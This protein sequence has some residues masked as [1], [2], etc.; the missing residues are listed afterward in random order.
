[1]KLIGYPSSKADL[2]ALFKTPKEAIDL[3]PAIL[4]KGLI[5]TSIEFMDQLSIITSCRYLNENLPYE[6]AGAML[7]I[8]LDGGN[9]AQIEADLIETGKLCEANGTLEVYVAEDRNSIERMERAP[10]Y[11][12]SL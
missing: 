9:A 8:E 4:S 12:R 1:V 3:V 6:N 10:E 7:L 2:L 11:C 5:P